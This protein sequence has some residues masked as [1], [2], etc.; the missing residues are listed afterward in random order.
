MPPEPLTA[1]ELAELA[2]QHKDISRSFTGNHRMMLS[3][4]REEHR[5][6]V[7]YTKCDITD[8]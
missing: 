4:P 7:S 5:L 2:D 6:V 1:D 3:I 8:K